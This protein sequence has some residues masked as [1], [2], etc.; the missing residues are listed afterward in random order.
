MWLMNWLLA[1]AVTPTPMA[2]AY[3]EAARVFILLL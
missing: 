3:Q 2:A 1:V